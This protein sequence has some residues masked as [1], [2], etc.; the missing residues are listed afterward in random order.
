MKTSNLTPTSYPQM[1][2]QNISLLGIW[3]SSLSFSVWLYSS[4]LWFFLH[5]SMLTLYKPL[6]QQDTTIVARAIPC[7][8]DHF[9]VLDDGTPLFSHSQPKGINQT[10]AFSGLVQKCIPA[11]HL[12]LPACVW[13]CYSIFSIQSVFLSAIRSYS[14]NL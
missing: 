7:I 13:Q 9:K 6:F 3:Q 10:T 2:N 5:I 1:E 4:W 14:W 12:R 8:T 11:H